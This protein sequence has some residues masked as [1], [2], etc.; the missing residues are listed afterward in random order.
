MQETVFTVF[1]V[2]TADGCFYS[3]RGLSLGELVRRGMERFAVPYVAWY[4]GSPYELRDF[5]PLRIM[6]ESIDAGR[7]IKKLGNG[8][9][10]I[11]G[12]P[13]E[14]TGLADQ[15]TVEQKE[16]KRPPLDWNKPT[17]FDPFPGFKTT[18]RGAY[19]FEEEVMESERDKLQDSPDLSP[20]SHLVPPNFGS[21]LINRIK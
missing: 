20:T 14:G 8:A 21:A 15:Q 1:T 6:Q 13:S 12:V 3:C 4:E 2:F 16:T 11:C 19:R 5:D 18:D 10:V 9:F 7:V 17:P